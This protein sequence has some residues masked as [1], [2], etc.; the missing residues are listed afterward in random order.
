MKKLNLEAM[1]IDDLVQRFASIGVAQDGALLDGRIGE[2]N[3]LFEAMGQVSQELKRRQGD[4]RRALLV[5]FGFPNMQVRLKAAIH[6]LAV[7]PVEARR[8]IEEIAASQWYPQ[9]GDAG[10]SLIN[11]DNGIF[12]PT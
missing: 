2:F 1:S 8:Q 6:A 3:R 4:Q 7:A 11:L 12:K 9:A 5:L 10:M